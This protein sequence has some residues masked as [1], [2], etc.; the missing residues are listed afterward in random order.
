[1]GARTADRVANEKWKKL[2]AD[3]QD[4]GIDPGVAEELKRF[5]AVRKEAIEHAPV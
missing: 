5:I 1:M 3:Y 4:P 2:L